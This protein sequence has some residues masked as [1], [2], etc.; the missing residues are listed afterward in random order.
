MTLRHDKTPL[1][2]ETEL[3]RGRVF[4]T[5]L[6]IDL[7]DALARDAARFGI[8]VSDVGLM[9]IRTGRVPWDAE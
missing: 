4:S 5:R 9:R 6:P 3:Q 8:S 7:F 1:E 2:T